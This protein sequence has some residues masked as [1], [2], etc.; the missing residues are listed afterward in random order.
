ME[1]AGRGRSHENL[2][3][4]AARLAPLQPDLLLVPSMTETEAGYN[5]VFSC[6]RTRA[7]ELYA[8]VCAV[9]VIGAAATGV[10]RAGYRFG[11]AAYVPSDSGLGTIGLW[12][13]RSR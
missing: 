5:R 3:A 10:P 6:A 12:G 9:G 2:P 7:T 8:V 1:P 11:A 13:G 4:L